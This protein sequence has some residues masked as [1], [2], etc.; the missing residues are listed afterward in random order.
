MP[1]QACPCEHPCLEHTGQGNAAA[2][3]FCVRRV[4]AHTA[5]ADRGSIRNRIPNLPGASSGSGLQSHRT[6]EPAIA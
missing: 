5:M 2:P 1:D 6:H 4:A 3:G